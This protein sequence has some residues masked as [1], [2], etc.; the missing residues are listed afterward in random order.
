MVR[1][2]STSRSHRRIDLF[3]DSR[4]RKIRCDGAKPKC[5]HC[6]QREGNDE[7]TYD[8]LPK[9]RGPDRTPG[10]RTRSTWPKDDGEP[11]PRRRR[12]RAKTVDQV[13]QAASGPYDI[14]RPDVT[15]KP[16]KPDTLEGPPRLVDPQP[17]GVLSE[18]DPGSELLEG[19]SALFCTTAS[20][21]EIFTVESTITGHTVSS[22]LV[23][24]SLSFNS[25][26]AFTRKSRRI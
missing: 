7:C 9:R 5:F 11:P 18:V 4:S 20:H 12:R 25:I 13:D 1:N 19:S 8:S 16:S 3:F 22:L 15:V 23:P 6:V 17:Y 10:A 26:L 2:I 24:Y 14:T 21:N